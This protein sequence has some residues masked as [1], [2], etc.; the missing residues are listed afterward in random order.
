MDTEKDF[1]E[2]IAN[3]RIDLHEGDSLM[4]QVEAET[5]KVLI[6]AT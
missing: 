1:H 3:T 4:F 6:E 2:A 5:V